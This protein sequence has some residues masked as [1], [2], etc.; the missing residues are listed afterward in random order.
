MG[1]QV[2]KSKEF[3]SAVNGP[4]SATLEWKETIIRSRGNI[5]LTNGSEKEMW[6][7]RSTNTKIMVQA[8]AGMKEQ[9]N[10][11]R[12]NEIQRRAS[13]WIN[14]VCKDAETTRVKL[15]NSWQ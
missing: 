11:E 7:R 6:M 15:R 3:I 1:W 5:S 8:G 14:Y 12:N 9:E 10:E 2:L 4:S 13:T